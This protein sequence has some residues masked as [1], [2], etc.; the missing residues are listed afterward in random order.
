MKITSSPNKSLCDNSTQTDTDSNKSKGLSALR[1]EKYDFFT[2]IDQLPTPRQ[3]LMQVFNEE[4]L[5]E[6]STKNLGPFLT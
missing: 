1:E 5:A 3:K 4:Y 2:E 6:N